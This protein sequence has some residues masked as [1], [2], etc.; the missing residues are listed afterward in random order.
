VISSVS[1]GLARRQELRTF[2][3]DARESAKPGD[4]AE[5]D[6]RLYLELGK[7]GWL[8]IGLPEEY[9]GSGGSGFEWVY[10]L[11][12]LMIT[13]PERVWGWALLQ[14]IV[15]GAVLRLARPELRD[16]VLRE[17]TAGTHKA[18]VAFTEPNAGSDTRA[19]QTRAEKDG[20]VYRLNGSKLYPVA[21]PGGYMLVTTRTR[22]DVSI[23]EGM[24]LFLV[25]VD[26]PGVELRSFKMGWGSYQQEILFKDVAV[27]EEYLIGVENAGWDEFNR[28][29]R[30][31]EWTEGRPTGRAANFLRSLIKH[32]KETDPDDPSSRELI[33]DLTAKLFVARVA[34][35]RAILARDT[36]ADDADVIEP[37]MNK[38]V[39]AETTREILDAIVRLTG[40]DGLYERE[41]G[42]DYNLPLKGRAPIFARLQ[43]SLVLAGWPSEVQRDFIADRVW[44]R[45]YDKP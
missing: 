1:T 3:A 25:P 14:S 39:N 33:A 6:E 26:L 15:R 2:L 23:S 35:F 5:F 34:Q 19:I 4:P 17:F 27:P 18:C 43:A 42:V 22:R 8:G 30:N 40:I 21:D 10:V 45:Q 12:E 11:T 28:A 37:A 41:A 38:M 7:A 44:P 24:S 20:D 29:V 36:A 32:I 9:G 31:Y 13:A 16:R